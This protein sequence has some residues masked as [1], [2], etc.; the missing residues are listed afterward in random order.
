M[1]VGVPRNIP[2]CADVIGIVVAI[3]FFSVFDAGGVG[4]FQE[5]VEDGV[6]VSAIAG[7]RKKRS[8]YRGGGFGESDCSGRLDRILN[9]VREDGGLENGFRF[10][11]G[12]SIRRSGQKL[13]CL[14]RFQFQSPMSVFCLIFSVCISHLLDLNE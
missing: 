14:K 12:C 1:T 7:S 10:G 9:S 11:R 4:P 13:T 3:Q 6:V 8:G 5:V 2:P